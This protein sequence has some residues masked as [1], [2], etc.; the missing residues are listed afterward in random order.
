MRKVASVIEDGSIVVYIILGVT[1]IICLSVAIEG[2][3]GAWKDR[4]KK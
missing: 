1:I 2:L 4:R 3:R